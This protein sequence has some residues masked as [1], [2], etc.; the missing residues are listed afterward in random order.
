MTTM[1]WTDERV[2]Q[3][4]KL[5]AD[6]LSASQIAA[7]TRAVFSLVDTV[8]VKPLPYPD[9]DALVTVYELSPSARERRTLVAPGR[10][11]DWQRANRSFV[12][13]SATYNESVTDTSAEEPERLAGVRVA[14]R[15]FDVYGQPPIAGRWFNDDEERE[16]G[17]NAAVISERFWIRRFNRAPS[18]IGQALMVGG[19]PSSSSAWWIASTA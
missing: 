6:G 5:W 8:L 16:A 15:F 7:V 13:I 3:L 4:K 9:A 12:A 11:Q 2:E 19:K 1:T 10:L 18:A 17:A 14:P